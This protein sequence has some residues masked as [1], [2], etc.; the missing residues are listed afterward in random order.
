[1]LN[2]KKD[3]ICWIMKHY[4]ELANVEDVVEIPF[5]TMYHGREHDTYQTLGLYIDLL[6]ASYNHKTGEVCGGESM[7]QQYIDDQKNVEKVSERRADRTSIFYKIENTSIE[8]GYELF[9]PEVNYLGF[10]KQNQE[11][12]G[13]SIEIN[14]QPVHEIS[15][16]VCG[17]YLSMGFPIF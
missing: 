3:P 17:N 5:S 6:P 16:F 10:L 13:D 14:M 9:Y 8:N 11:E 15:C 4:A 2:L 12:I 1:I 7:I